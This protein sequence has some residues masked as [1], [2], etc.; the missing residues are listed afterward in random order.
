MSDKGYAY[1]ELD[2]IDEAVAGLKDDVTA[3]A[4]ELGENASDTMRRTL[5]RIE[6]T[7]SDLYE[8]LAEQGSRG[9]EAIERQ[10][11]ERPWTSLAVAFGLGVL[12][13]IVARGD[14]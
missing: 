11:D 1:D 10:V 3:L 13:G 9:V 8:T 12:I 5:R 4:D 2:E 7:A 14:R 6:E